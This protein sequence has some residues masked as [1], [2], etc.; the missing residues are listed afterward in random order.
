MIGYFWQ[1]MSENLI[2]EQAHTYPTEWNGTEC[3]Q[4]WCLRISQT[5]KHWNIRNQNLWLVPEFFFLPVRCSKNTNLLP[6]R[7]QKHYNDDGLLKCHNH[8]VQSTLTHPSTALQ[9]VT[10]QREEK[11][12]IHIWLVLPHSKHWRKA[13]WEEGQLHP[14]GVP[15]PTS[16]VLSLPPLPHSTP[17]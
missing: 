11:F 15:S 13:V 9:W 16:Q 7:Y 10:C 2:K 1:L 4:L 14:F 17:I 12:N 8:Y 3:S 5:N 6:L